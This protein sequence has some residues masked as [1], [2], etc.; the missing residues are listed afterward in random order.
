MFDGLE[1]GMVIVVETYSFPT[2]G[3]VVGW[4]DTRL[5]LKDTVRV[6]YDGRHGEFAAGKPP[7]NAEIEM[8]YPLLHLAFDEVRAWAPCPGGKVPRP[9]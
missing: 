2:I 6:L 1:K 3:V 7:A 4:D 8:S 9:Q 5:T